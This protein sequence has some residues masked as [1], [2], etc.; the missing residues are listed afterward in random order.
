MTQAVKAAQ[1]KAELEEELEIQPEIENGVHEECVTERVTVVDNEDADAQETVTVRRK[2]ADSKEK[3]KDDKN[4]EPDH[5][6][7]IQ[8]IIHGVGYAMHV[9]LVIAERIIAGLMNLYKST[10]MSHAGSIKSNYYEETAYAVF[11]KGEYQKAL[12][13]FER[14]IESGVPEDSNMLSCMGVAHAQL[15]Q[16]DIAL[17]YLKKVEDHMQDDIDVL[18]EIANCLIKLEDY[19]SAIEYLTK[20]IEYMPDN[21]ETH[22]LLGSSY[23]KIDKVKDAVAMYKQAIELAPREPIFYQ[24]LGFCYEGASK[25]KDAIA[26][27]KKAMELEKNR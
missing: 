3:V 25:H 23:E 14:A 15:E 6:G 4:E 7:K 13:L 19:P 12:T 21:A 18:N 27:F 22:Y 17:A 16:Y 24:A 5:A 9:V 20:A 8:E 10:F 26:C 2:V 1:P 11:Q